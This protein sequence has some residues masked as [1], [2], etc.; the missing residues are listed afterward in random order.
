MCEEESGSNEEAEEDCALLPT[1]PANGQDLQRLSLLVQTQALAFNAALGL[2]KTERDVRAAHRLLMHP[3]RAPFKLIEA[4]RQ[5]LAERSAQLDTAA[6]EGLSTA[7]G[8]T[9]PQVKELKASLDRSAYSIERSVARAVE[10]VATATTTTTA[11]KD[12]EAVFQLRHAGLQLLFFVS[13]VDTNAVWERVG[14]VGHN[15]MRSC[16]EASRAPDASPAKARSGNGKD[17]GASRWAQDSFPVVHKAFQDS[18]RS[19]ER[20]GK[21]DVKS[22]GFEKLVETWT[23]LAQKVSRFGRGETCLWSAELVGSDS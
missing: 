20:T 15:H 6:A 18:V 22:P 13:E 2:A 19:A 14:R 1:L 21:L 9:N 11:T 3:E 5:V 23:T 12:H 17:S 16:Y 7:E 4:A 8:E 10:K